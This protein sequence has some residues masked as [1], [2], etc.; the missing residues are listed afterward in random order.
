[1]LDA[2]TNPVGLNTESI[3]EHNRSLVLRKLRQVDV[4][5]RANL[6][7]MVGLERATITNII[8]NFINW[9]VVRETGIIKEKRVGALSNLVERRQIQRDRS[10]AGTKLCGAG[11]V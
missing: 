7:K 1:M 3:Q 5:S 4:C 6:S 10:S 2:F 9:G 8:N 11:C